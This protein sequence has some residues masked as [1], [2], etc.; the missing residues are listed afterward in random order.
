MKKGRKIYL[1][2]PMGVNW[3][4]GETDISRIANIMPPI[5]LCSLAAWVEKHGHH[6]AIHDCYAFPLEDDKILSNIESDTPDFVG[7][8]T[9][10]SSF[11]DGIRIAKMIKDKNPNIPVIFGGVH[12]TSMR[13]GLMK[14]YPIIDYGVVGEGEIPLLSLMDED[15]GSLNDVPGLLYRENDEVKYG[16]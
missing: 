9:T 15:Y 2:H 13:E 3:M 1:I 10:T 11:L 4:P 7:I 5:G 16:L 6:A 8:T 14:D 12:V